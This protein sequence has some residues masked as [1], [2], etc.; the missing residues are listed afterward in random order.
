M[1]TNPWVTRL[2]YHV[3]LMRNELIEEH[4]RFDHLHKA[5]QLMQYCGVRDACKQEEKTIYET[6]NEFRIKGYDC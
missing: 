6:E 2:Q 1:S 3:Q 4:E 5:K